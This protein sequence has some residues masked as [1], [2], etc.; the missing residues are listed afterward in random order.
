MPG[1]LLVSLGRWQGAYVLIF[2]QL[3]AS[4]S[5]RKWDFRVT[6]GVESQT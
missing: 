6:V 4:H 3:D 1:A 5:H 2:S